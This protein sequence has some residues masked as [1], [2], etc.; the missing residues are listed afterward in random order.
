MPNAPA[1]AEPGGQERALGAGA[2]L[3][4]ALPG[5]ERHLSRRVLLESARELGI[6]GVL[7]ELLELL[8]VLGQQ[9]DVEV[10]H[11]GQLDAVG[12]QLPVSGL[13]G[14]LLDVRRVRH[15]PENRPAV[16]DDLRGDVS[17]EHLEQLIAH[18]GGDPLVVG[19]VDGGGHVGD[20][21]D[22]VDHP[23]RVVAEDAQGHD[24]PAAR[25]LHVVDPPAEPETGVLAGA[26]EVQLGAVGV[27]AGDA[28]DDR[29]EARQ[30]VRVD[31]VP[32]RPRVWTTWPVL[33][34]IATWSAFT[35][36]R[37]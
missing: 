12:G 27:A 26:D 16:P 4:H 30:L 24:Q 10:A 29:A 28:V 1:H 21:P 14:G 18:P 22:R 36:A 19:H 8:L 23:Q 11:P 35:I 31:L 32:P 7:G 2:A 3:G 9:V 20:Q 17:P 34:N 25:V 15:Q 5:A 13:D 6:A 33:T 37:V